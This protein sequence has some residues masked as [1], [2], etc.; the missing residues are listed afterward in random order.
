LVDFWKWFDLVSGVVAGLIAS[1][2]SAP[3]APVNLII[4]P[5][6]TDSPLLNWYSNESAPVSRAT[7]EFRTT[8][9]CLTYGQG[10]GDANAFYFKSNVLTVGSRYSMSLWIKNSPNLQSFRIDFVAGANTQTLTTP[11]ILPNAGY[12]QYK[13]ENVLCTTNQNL[14]V[15]V[16]S[17]YDGYI[18]DV[19][20]VLGS[21]A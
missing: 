17:L 13:I 14:Q 1:V 20:V 19:S 16:T 12:T 9:A 10:D 2:K 15:G 11:L 18:D 8:P 6:F 7:F 21:T 3:S 4:N 5:S